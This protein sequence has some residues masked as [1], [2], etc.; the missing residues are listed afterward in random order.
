MEEGGRRGE[1]IQCECRERGKKGKQLRV[2]GREGKRERLGVMALVANF[3]MEAE[4]GAE[5]DW[6]P[7]A[8]CQI[9]PGTECTKKGREG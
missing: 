6:L 7:S 1:G 9:T 5:K 4:R 8:F 2:R 3:P